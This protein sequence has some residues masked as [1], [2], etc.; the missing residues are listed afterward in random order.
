MKL[1]AWKSKHYSV[2]SPMSYYHLSLSQSLKG[3]ARYIAVHAFYTK[4]DAKQHLINIGWDTET[5]KGYELVPF[6]PSPT[7]TNG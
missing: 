2:N 6:I 5:I 1:Y 3:G 4:K 7:K